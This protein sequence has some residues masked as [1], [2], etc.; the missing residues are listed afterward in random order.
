MPGFSL[1]SVLQSDHVLEA[2]QWRYLYGLAGRLGLEHHLFTRKRVDALAR[3][4]CRLLDDPHF[5]KTRNS[6]QARCATTAKI[7]LD[8]AIQ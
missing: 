6:E 4:A 7:L 1:T 5:Q 3:F 2:F 8:L